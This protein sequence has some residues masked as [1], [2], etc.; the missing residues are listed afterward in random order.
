PSERLANIAGFPDHLVQGSEQGQILYATLARPSPG[1]CDRGVA[2]RELAGREHLGGHC[3][4]RLSLAHAL[5]K[6]AISAS[7][8]S[9]VEISHARGSVRG[10]DS[11]TA[12]DDELRHLDDRLLKARRASVVA[13][14][15]DVSIPEAKPRSIGV[16][17][18][19]ADLRT[20]NVVAHRH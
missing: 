6:G 3:L 13:I 19:R 7:G 16:L 20:R 4:G 15:S 1:G 12:R 10:F 9:D 18:R 5:A 2:L 11:P 14:R 8:C 17:H